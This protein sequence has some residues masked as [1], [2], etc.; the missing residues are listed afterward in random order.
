[1]KREI[2][3]F[4][5]TIYEKKVLRKRAERAGVSLSEY[6]RVSA[7]G[8]NLVER[9]TEEQLERYR[10]LVKYKNNFTRI[11]NMFKGRDPKLA[12]EVRQLAK[13]IK[14]QLHNFNK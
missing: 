11:G 3:K 8:N 10:M 6:C 12:H 7:F 5:C 4:R 13:E 2:I 14:N 9:L 1:M